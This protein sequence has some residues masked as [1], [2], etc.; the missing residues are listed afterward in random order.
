MEILFAL[1]QTGDYSKHG[2]YIKKHVR[3]VHT[4]KK[5]SSVRRCFLSPTCECG[6][7]KHP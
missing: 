5:Y 6:Y 7:A 3:N 1:Y 4:L 2:F